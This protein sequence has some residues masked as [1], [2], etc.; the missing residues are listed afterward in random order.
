[1]KKLMVK[2]LGNEKRQAVTIPIFAILVSLIAGAIVLLALGKNPLV[3]YMNLL[4]GSGILPKSTYAGGRN[5]LTDFM[6]FMNAWTP[7]LF[8]ALAFTVAARAGLFNIGIAGQMLSSGF[9]AT[10]LIGY[11][12]LPAVAAKPLVIVVG[13]ITGALLGALVGWLKYRFNINEVVS[14]IMVNYIAQYVISFFINTVYVDPVSRQSRNI[15][16]ASRLTLMD[17]KIG[18]LKM[19]IPLGIILAIIAAFA[20]RFFLNRTKTGFEIKMVGSSNTAAK[21]AGVN[22]GKNVVLAM[23][24]SGALAGLAGVTYY[25]GYFGSIQP[26]VL[27]STG[28]DCIAVALLGGSNPI[29]IIFS[30]FLITVISKGSTYMTSASGVDSEIASVITGLI[31]LF[32]ACSAFIA[33]KVNQSK[34]ALEDEKK[35]KEKAGKEADHE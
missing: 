21:Y 6:S 25:L 27:P 4:Q 30:S 14:T 13:V 8:A 7:M 11:S 32:S 3:A 9:L 35:A 34:R 20:V 28:Y 16:A 22:V 19:D 5:M 23:V 29:G 26:K 2:L 33:Y 10:I 15:S 12:N 1:M 17:T 24:L 31:L 18:G